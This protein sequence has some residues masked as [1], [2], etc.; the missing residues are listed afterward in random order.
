[1]L[2]RIGRIGQGGRAK[3]RQEAIERV[4]AFHQEISSSSDTELAERFN[5]AENLKLFATS[6]VITGL[7]VMG[8]AIGWHEVV[9]NEAVK[10]V[11]FVPT[12]AGSAIAG[13]GSYLFLKAKITSQLITTEAQKR[14]T[15]IIPGL[16]RSLETRELQ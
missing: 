3:R 9:N 1:M 14:G 15:K 2:E 6:M 13:I 10:Q 7:T 4:A 5:D 16:H 11:M 12:A 8:T